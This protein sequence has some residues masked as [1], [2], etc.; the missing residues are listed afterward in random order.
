MALRLIFLIMGTQILTLTTSPIELT[1]G[2]ETL[3]R[4]IGKEISHE[5]AMM[6]SIALRFIASTSDARTHS[7]RFASGF[8]LGSSV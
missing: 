2:I 6:M 5:L 4:P 1:D 8:F 7:R 3:L